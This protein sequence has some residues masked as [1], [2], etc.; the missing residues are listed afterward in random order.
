MNKMFF[1]SVTIKRS[2]L[3][4]SLSFH[5][6]HREKVTEE[7]YGDELEKRHTSVSDFIVHQRNRNVTRCRK[8]NKGESQREKER[9]RER[10]R[11]PIENTSEHSM[12]V[13]TFDSNL[14]VYGSECFS[15]DVREGSLGREMRLRGKQ[16][17]RKGR[18]SAL[19]KRTYRARYETGYTLRASWCSLAPVIVTC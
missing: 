12:F 4:G 16:R 9:E 8:P 17:G 2:V 7:Q 10:N 3:P 13:R 5:K 11:V 18:G 19:R 14:T 1:S 15:M 6:L